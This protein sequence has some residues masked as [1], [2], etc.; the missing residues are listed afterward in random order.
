[1]DS[2]GTRRAEARARLAERIAADRERIVR[3]LQ[4]FVRIPSE[5][6]PGDTQ[7]VFAWATRLLDAADLEYE[8]VAPVPEWPNL[9]ASVEGAKSGRHLILNGHFDVFP[10]GD[11]ATWSDD[12]FSGAIADGKLYGRGVADMKTGTLAMILTYLYLAELRDQLAGKLTLTIVSDEETGGTW[13][14][15]YL[16]E[17][18]PDLLGDAVLNGEPTTPG[19]VLVGEKGPIMLELTVK[20]RGGHSATPEV[21]ENAIMI[22]TQILGELGSLADLPVN[23]PDEVRRIIET[24]RQATGDS[25]ALDLLT[26]LTINVGVIEGGYKVNVIPSE[27]RVQI[28]IRCPFGLSNQ[29]VLE[30]LDAILERYPG[31]SYRVMVGNDANYN[32]PDVDLL[33]ILQRNAEAFLGARP[34]PSLI[35]AGSDGRFWRFKGVPA[36]IY[37]PTPYGIAAPDEHVDLDE[38]VGLVQVHALSAFDYLTG[39]TE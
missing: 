24:Q 2:Q 31:A 21:S 7:Q 33:R 38:I 39:A 18:R 22:A 16:T 25:V 27:C 23:P 32:S 9:V 1:M 14:A 8:M 13:G 6:P 28:D 17:H 26:K 5:N 20:T 4:E 11:P 3:Q 29:T 10:A 12:P 30:R 34:V 35:A 36:V 15:R 19:A 37:G